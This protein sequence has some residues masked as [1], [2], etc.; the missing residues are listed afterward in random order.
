MSFGV[1]SSGKLSFGN[2]AAVNM[3]FWVPT[4]LCN[5]FTL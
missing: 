2:M 5:S 1:M 4:K 3:S